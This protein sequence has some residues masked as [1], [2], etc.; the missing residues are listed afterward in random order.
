M[1]GFSHADA[2]YAAIS[3]L[4]AQGCRR[5]RICR[6]AHG[7]AGAAA[8]SGLPGCHEG[9]RTASIRASSSPRR[10]RPPSR[11]AARCLPICSPR[12]RI[13]MRCSA[14]MTTSALGALF[15]CRR[16]HIAVPEQM[17]IVGF[18][19]LEIHG[20]FRPYAQ[21]R[22]HQSLRNGQE[23]CHDGDRGDRRPAAGARG[24]R[25][26]LPCDDAAKFVA[27]D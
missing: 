9:R 18:N 13:P 2:C 15:E 22:A 1:I 25:S 11:S 19:D 10:R 6:R 3:H 12:R 16:R 21:Q 5:N 24:R 4:L 7:S 17:A 26:R 27:A 20:V 14:P 23:R 8:V